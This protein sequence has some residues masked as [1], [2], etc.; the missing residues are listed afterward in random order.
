M[1]EMS[2]HSKKWTLTLAL[3]ACAVI[4]PYA[5][6][7][8]PPI[9]VAHE[10]FHGWKSI[11]LRNA[12]AEVVVV[13]EVGRVMEFNL[14]DGKGHAQGSFWKNPA[15][16]KDLKPDAE[17]W[18]NQGGDKAWPAPQ[19]EWPKIA[20]RGWPP[21]T[22]FDAAPY[23]ASIK[24]AKVELLSPFDSSYGIRV[25]RTIA[26]D[27]LKPVM[28]IRT[29]YEK[30]QG[31]PVPIAVWTIT[32]VNPPERAYILLPEH[33]A[34]PQGYTNLLPGAPSNP[35]VNGRLL[36]V[37]R[38][39]RQ[40]TMLGSDG[41]TLLWV[42]DGP[43]LLI[44]NKSPQAADS[45]AQWPEQG[46]HSKIYTNA[47]EAA[48]YVELELLNSVQTLKPGQ[49]ASMTTTYT[50]VART[51]SDPLLEAEK[52]LGQSEDVLA[53]SRRS[54]ETWRNSRAA[55]L[56]NDFG[57]LAR[58]RDANAQLKPP[59]AGERRVVF[60]G[61]S[62][63]DIWPLEQ[64]F[65]G[66]GYINRGI[67]G[68]TTP[69]MLVRFREDVI[70]LQPAVVVILAGTNDI[71]GNTGPMSL[72]EIE[73]NYA[74]MAELG[75][76][77]N[78][79]VVFSSVIPVHNYTPKAA[80]FFVQRPMSKIREL[81]RWMQEYCR[82]N[83][84]VYLDYFNALIDDAGF[85]KKELADDGLHPNPAGYSIMAPLASEAIEKALKP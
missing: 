19:A 73:A 43:D 77:H 35:N 32:Q 81:N 59:V 10:T 60:M 29:V 4:A 24:D 51:E 39:P 25:R 78:I 52:V 71:A 27:P 80:N 79:R 49:E 37:V 57:E 11:V 65:P 36:S 31:P 17:G 47:A 41:E 34:L 50:L 6:A 40:N 33:S 23:T 38:D 69:Q 30:V 26:L 15:F 42:G 9:A 1:P 46:S 82:V 5:L 13:P 58:Y 45:G 84:Y 70:N 62:I 74:S 8:D 75:R 2:T 56:R 7:A 12:V 54:L 48:K 67:G 68:Q 3:L 61:D 66:K 76:A 20:R 83:G 16:G 72:E 14:L 21:P 28:T 64:Y 53:A 22:T 85:L 44:E 18:I 63:T 55:M